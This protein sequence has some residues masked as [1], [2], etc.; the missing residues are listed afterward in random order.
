M[1]LFKR[2][3]LLFFLMSISGGYALTNYCATARSSAAPNASYTINYTCRNVSGTTYEFK[4]EYATAITAVNNA[5]IGANPGPIN[6]G[7]NLVFSN[8]N[9][10]LSYQ[11]TAAGTPSL[12]VATIFLN[13]GGTEVRWD[14]PTDAN[15]AA[16]CSAG[17]HPPT[18]GTFTVP[19]KVVGN[20][21]FTI[22]P[23]S[24]NSTGAFTYT[25]SNTAVA[26]IVN[27]NMIHIVGAGTSTITATQAADATHSVGSTSATFT[28]TPASTTPAAGPTTPPARNPWMF[29][30]ST[31]LPI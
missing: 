21:D 14:L 23:P 8:G 17:N 24:S 9:K 29:Y 16:T 5:N 20:A 31:A 6:I 3:F 18:F 30:L 13:I 28:V 7:A 10:T 11:F 1:K 15:F 25:S 27:T 26:T 2:L 12:Y 19:A 4:L 22:T